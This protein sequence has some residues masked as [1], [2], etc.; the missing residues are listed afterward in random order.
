MIL[1]SYAGSLY[2]GWAPLDGT[3]LPGDWLYAVDL[4]IGS[5][6][7]YITSLDTVDEDDPVQVLAGLNIGW[8]VSE[9]KP[10]PAQP[11][12]T[13]LSVSFLSTD[14][15]ELADIGIGTPIAC[16]L[17][18]GDGHTIGTFH[19]RIASE[20][21]R[22]YRRGETIY[23]LFSVAG[24][25]YAVDLNEL[26]IL[27]ATWP[28]ESADARFQ[29]ISDTCVALGGVAIT[30]PP[31]TSTAAFEELNVN[32]T[33]GGVLVDHLDQLAIDSAE[34]VQRYIVAPVVVGDTSL[35]R[36]DCVLLDRTTD[37]S[38]LPGTFEIVDGILTLTYPDLTADGIVD[39]G[40]VDLD[41]TWNRL[42]YRAINR[43][44]V[45][46][47]T[48]SYELVPDSSAP[49]VR[50]NLSTTLTD[51]DAAQRMARL[52]LPDE[53][54]TQ[55][56][57]ADRFRLYAHENLD[58]IRPQWFPDHR[59]DPGDTGV[60]VMPLAIV[61]IVEAVT[62]DGDRTYAGQLTS[63]T[64]TIDRNRHVLVDFTLRRQLPVGVGTGAATWEWA[65][66]E[67][68]TVTWEE[69]DP[70]LSWYEARLGKA[71]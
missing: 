39:A 31:D 71:T 42:K 55:G 38:L 37:A 18:D 4:T 65:Q 56:W 58:T 22:P 21:V 43:V 36:F 57:V 50:L 6:H 29:R 17:T 8:Q 19:G 47:D 16:V 1:G 63:V 11:E 33:I 26:Q 40:I 66:S 46:G 45:S 28:A 68:P 32:G 34:G 44:T 41:V 49:P 10:W 3:A 53:D 20:S 62:L 30:P 60:Y 27:P 64:L 23:A 54:E 24:V 13:T 25:G 14:A 69:I 15:D 5:H 52:Y 59:D 67:F 61:D 7:W 48:V 51:D 70:G 12:A 2:A 9:A 35:E